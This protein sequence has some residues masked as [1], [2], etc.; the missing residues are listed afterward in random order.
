M[1]ASG[2]FHRDFTGST[3]DGASISQ[4]VGSSPIV[5][6]PVRVLLLFSDTG[7][8]HRSAAEALIE[9]WRAEHPGRVDADMVDVFR[10]YTPFP[11]NQAPRT[12]PFTIRYFP[13]LYA[14][15]FYGSDSPGRARALACAS[16]P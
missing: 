13:P 15:T 12:Y 9:A 4:S 5:E 6:R 11:F 2:A 14:A 10:G 7:G 3:R 16:Y 1:Q 8:G